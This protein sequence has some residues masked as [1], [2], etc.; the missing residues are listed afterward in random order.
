[1]IESPP[2]PV[3]GAGT[4]SFRVLLTRAVFA[5]L[6]LATPVF[7]VLVYRTFYA[8]YYFVTAT[9]GVHTQEVYE[10]RLRDSEAL[11]PS[12]GEPGMKL[13]QLLRRR[14]DLEAAMSQQRV[15]ME[16]FQPYD[17][18]E[19]LGRNYEAAGKMG[20]AK[21]TFS[22]MSRMHP[23][24]VRP[25]EWLAVLAVRDRDSSEATRLTRE[26]LRLDMSN[27]NAPYLRAKDAEMAGDYNTALSNYQ[28][29][30]SALS[31]TPKP[32]PNL[33]FKPEEIEKQLIE[34]R[35]ALSK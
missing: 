3:A 5:C 32:P 27:L 15:S 19:Q 21:R 26:I 24:D 2:S 31:R 29:I 33:L 16:S 22:R 34:V 35:K 4:G 20:D 9:W 25:L 10:Q 12:F 17:T 18:F 11:D 30:G 13:S 28:I 23:G 7:S 1:M 8:R 6:V 14:G